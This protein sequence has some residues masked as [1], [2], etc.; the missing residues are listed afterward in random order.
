MAEKYT[1]KLNFEEFFS[2][3]KRELTVLMTY[4]NSMFIL[5]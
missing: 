1:S 2:E 4:S 3:N 5:R